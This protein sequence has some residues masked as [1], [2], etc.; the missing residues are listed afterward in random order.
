MLRSR[1]SFFGKLRSALGPTFLLAIVLALGPTVAVPSATAQT[2]FD[3]AGEFPGTNFAK[4]SIELSEIVSGGPV[5]DSIPLIDD[6]QFVSVATDDSIDPLEP[7]L[8]VNINGDFRAYPLRLLLFH[9]LVTDTVGGVPVLV[10]YCPLCNS[11]VV[12]DRRLDGKVLE[13]GNTGR[14]RNFNMVIYD[15]ATE[16]WW[17]QF[18]GE[19]FMGDLTGSLLK[20]LP[21]RLESLGKFRARAPEGLLLI[22]NDE[23]ARPY[24]ETPYSGMNAQQLPRSIARDRF[25]YE[26]PESVHP[27]DR[28][29]VVGDEA[30]TLDILRQAGRIQSGSLVM[31]WEAGQNSIFDSREISAGRDVGNVVV[32]RVTEDGLEDEVYDVSF[33]F[34]YRAFNPEGSLH[35]E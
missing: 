28:V 4:R 10:T 19:A 23:S 21:A 31:T 6:P 29:V 14:L 11:G 1:V 34:A 15:K 13:F 26:L 35:F 32:Q 25:P 20:A 24:G 16:S 17:Q 7:V 33:A 18:A 5:R 27:L 12:Y 22:P 3:L 2:V 30:W 8:S 9:E